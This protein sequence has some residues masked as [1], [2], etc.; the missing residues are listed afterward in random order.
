MKLKKIKKNCKITRGSFTSYIYD[1]HC[2]MNKDFRKRLKILQL[3][4]SFEAAQNWK[5]HSIAVDLNLPSCFNLTE[6][7]LFSAWL[8]CVLSFDYYIFLFVMKM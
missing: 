3:Y 8:A 7:T 4:T 5:E 6:T 1:Y 2:S